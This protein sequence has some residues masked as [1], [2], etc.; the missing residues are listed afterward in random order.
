MQALKQQVLSILRASAHSKSPEAECERILFY[1]LR[2]AHADIQE[3]GDLARMTIQPDESECAR[4][5]MI[6]GDRAKGLPLQHLLGFQFFYSRDYRVDP[7]TLI[8]R[9]ETEVLI[10]EAIRAIRARFGADAFR[11]AELGLGT[12]ILSAEILSHFPEARGVASECSG[13]AIELARRN[14]REAAGGS[15]RRLKILETRPDEGFEALAPEGPFEVVLSNPPYVSRD[16][17]I[18]PEV[19][20][21]EPESALFPA[22]SPDPSRFYLDFLGQASTLLAPDGLVFFEIPHE[23]A[24]G[25]EK[26]FLQSGLRDVRIIPDLTGRPRVLTARAPGK[27]DPFWKN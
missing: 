11:F 6:A 26:R 5:L 15:D 8:P 20:A 22:G 7:S 12:G 19:L 18:D 9:P 3:P 24:S 25:I 27:G 23:R 4:I 1:V 17:E 2:E 10:D 16:D 14:L 13:R 21:H